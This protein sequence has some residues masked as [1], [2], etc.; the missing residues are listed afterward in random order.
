MLAAEISS[1]KLECE[2]R[3]RLARSRANPS[4]CLRFS[5]TMF[6]FQPHLLAKAAQSRPAAPHPPFSFS[7]A[8]KRGQNA[9]ADGGAEAWG[10]P[11]CARVQ[12]YWTL[13]L[14]QRTLHDI[15]WLSI[16]CRRRAYGC[17]C[18]S[19]SSGSSMSCTAHVMPVQC[20]N[21]P[22]ATNITAVTCCRLF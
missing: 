21:V 3:C 15:Q 9:K 18:D 16:L 19:H 13:L 20:P 17:K 22:S 2:Y 4:H 11:A 1:Q 12:P 7:S 6:A 8:R 10:L 14:V 5:G